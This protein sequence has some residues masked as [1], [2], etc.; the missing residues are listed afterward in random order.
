MHNKFL[1][2]GQHGYHPVQK[3]K[4]V[5]KGL[6]FAVLSDVSV[7]YKVVLSA[8]LFVPVLLFNGLF[9]ASIILLAT[10]VMLSAEIFNTAIEAICD[11]MKTDF[12]EKIGIVKDVSAAATGVAIFIWVCVLV[13]E[14][15]EV[16]PHLF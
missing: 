11:Y 2:T 9:D 4:I 1:Q 15:I 3:L 16:W 8:L 6:R 5:F 7:L 12:D 13:I 14:T 10:G